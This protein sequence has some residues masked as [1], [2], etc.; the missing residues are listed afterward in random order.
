V[1]FS[2][3]T[4]SPTQKLTALPVVPTPIVIN[5]PPSNL[6]IPM[7]EIDSSGHLNLNNI[8]INNDVVHCYP[9]YVEEINYSPDYKNVLVLVHCIE[10]LN[11]LFLFRADGYS[12]LREITADS[13]ETILGNKYSWSPDGNSIVYFRTSCCTDAH[14]EVWAGLVRYDVQTADRKLL[15]G[16]YARWLL[17]PKTST[18]A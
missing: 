6:N 11:Q 15:V 14:S 16:S 17:A 4:L 2:S 12:L 18:L 13:W 10:E 3:T 7:P 8:H 1:P 9:G 5:S